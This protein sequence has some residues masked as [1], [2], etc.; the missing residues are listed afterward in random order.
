MSTTRH[1]WK[2]TE[3]TPELPV[4]NA[5]LNPALKP[6][7]PESASRMQEG[8]LRSPQITRLGTTVRL[9][10]LTEQ[11]SCPPG[12]RNLARLEW[13]RSLVTRVLPRLIRD[14]VSCLYV[15]IRTRVRISTYFLVGFRDFLMGKQ[16]GG[17][18]RPQADGQPAWA[19]AHQ[20]SEEAGSSRLNWPASQ[21]AAT[22]GFS[23]V[24]SAVG[25]ST[26]RYAQ[27]PCWPRRFRAVPS[28]G[29]QAVPALALVP[30]VLG[31]G[32]AA[33]DRM[34]MPG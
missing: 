7:Q 15:E 33:P 21:V 16:D 32:N 1:Q 14:L 6:G 13:W 19:P 26:S 30:E 8:R 9:Q 20:P 25:S 4:L 29:P 3:L 10:V 12:S 23:A 27:R 2:R 22:W 17:S 24:P 34:I 5:G 28:P 31:P 18:I 11:E